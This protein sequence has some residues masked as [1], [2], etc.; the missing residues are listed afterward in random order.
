V[1]GA[2][3][4]Y[5]LSSGVGGRLF[6]DE[7]EIQLTRL[8]R[9]PVEI[10]DVQ[11]RLEG[12]LRLEAHEFEAFPSDES[13]GVPAIRA[14]RIVAWIDVLAL[15]IGRLELSTLVLEGPF[16]TVEQNAAGRFLDLPLPNLELGPIDTD[17]GTLSETL[18][19]RIEG[20]DPIAERLFESI[21]AADRIEILDGTILWRRNAED[22]SADA[23]DE[24]RLELFTAVIERDWLS[25]DLDLE[26]SAVVVD[27]EHSPFSIGV[28]VE[29][30]GDETDFDW[31]VTMSQIPLAAA[32]TPL[33]A[34]KRI[35]GLSGQLTTLLHIGTAPNGGR[36][37][38]IDG[39]IQDAIVGLRRSKSKIHHQKLTLHAEIEIQ[40]KQLRLRDFHLEGERLGLDLKGTI[41]RP[42]RPH[43]RRPSGSW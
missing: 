31:T 19:S 2:G 10:G 27:G 16:L 38:R 11:I 43:R 9:G 6:H 40:E 34:F 17:E 21:R 41:S 1:V 7:I 28:A 29:R 20:L 25:E 18:V 35:D 26:F 24:I 5:L 3:V 33:F 14:R 37:L 22:D 42:I 8:L 15:L 30:G 32:E 12:G 39:E 36:R 4:A 23:P 13:A